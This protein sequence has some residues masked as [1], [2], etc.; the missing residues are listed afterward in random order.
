[1]NILSG[2]T[3]MT[4]FV[5]RAGGT[6]Q[7]MAKKALRTFGE[8]ADAAGIILTQVEMEYAPYFKYAAAYTNEN[9]GSRA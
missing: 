7:D 4:V 3:D 2:M 5:V 6:S 9:S 8:T 1:V